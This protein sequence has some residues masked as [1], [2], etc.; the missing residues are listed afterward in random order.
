[1]ASPLSRRNFLKLAAAGLGSLP[2][3]FALGTIVALPRSLHAAPARPLPPEDQPG[4][5]LY[6]RVQAPALYSYR[7]PSRSS[8]RLGVQ[9]FDQVF[10]L[11]ARVPGEPVR[12]SN[13]YWVRVAGAYLHSS[14][15]QPIRPQRN[16]PIRAVPPGGFAGEITAPYVDA[17]ARP[18]PYGLILYRLYFQSAHWVV[19]TV[20]DFKDH[21]W[22]KLHDERLDIHYYVPAATVRPVPPAELAPLAPGTPG[23]RIVVSLG[24][25][26][27]WA[28]EGDR[29]LLDTRIASG[30]RIY[31]DEAFTGKYL[32]PTGSF[33]VDRKQPHRH[34]GNGGLA[35]E[36]DYELPGVPWVSY[37]HWTGVAFHGTYWHNDYGY[38]QSQGCINMTP[39]DARWIYRWTDPQPQYAQDVVPGE[40]TEVEV[41]A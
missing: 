19:G 27:L 28:Y 8:P 2:L 6:G 37:F 25:Q 22:Y 13:P 16:A 9:F 15:V 10:P 38:P 23:K 7:D 36:S 35:A 24:Q 39:E 33:R 18:D 41:T 29:L 12:K 21:P 14:Y 26:R 5:P 31:K 34:M 40:G 32:T 3:R 4:P 11:Y 30:A 20:Y 1:M 17:R